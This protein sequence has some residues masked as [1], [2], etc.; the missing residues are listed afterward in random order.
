[1]C[2]CTS[3]CP[4]AC[5]PPSGVCAIGTTPS[6]RH[7]A[8]NRGCTR[9]VLTGVLTWYVTWYSHGIHRGT[10]GVLM[11]CQH[12]VSRCCCP[13]PSV[14]VGTREY[15]EYRGEHLRK[16]RVVLELVDRRPN[17]RERAHVAGRARMCVRVCA[18]ACACACVRAG[19]RAC[20]RA[21]VR[22]CVFL[23]ASS[24]GRAAGGHTRAVCGPEY[25]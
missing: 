10:H 4:C 21:G 17:P 20:A 2:V 18:C 8:T 19:G 24:G 3:V 5:T 11:R 15:R 13:P 16:V 22:A 1:V 12:Q 9:R 23:R 25:G 6:S 14:P 7:R